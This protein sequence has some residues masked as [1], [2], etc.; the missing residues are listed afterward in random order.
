MGFHHLEGPHMTINEIIQLQ[1]PWENYSPES[2]KRS[3]QRQVKAASKGG[4][5]A[6][7]KKRRSKPTALGIHWRETGKQQVLSEE[8]TDGRKLS[9][10]KTLAVGCSTKASRAVVS[11][12]P[13]MWKVRKIEITLHGTQGFSAQNNSSNEG[14][15]T[16]SL[17]QR[18]ARGMRGI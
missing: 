4:T 3:P 13:E 10:V 14:L 6:W 8:R 7:L 2:W 1:R 17:S 11:P 5:S 9:K 15:L 12:E 16:P 18:W